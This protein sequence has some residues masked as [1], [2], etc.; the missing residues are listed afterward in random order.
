MTSY[1]LFGGR[2]SLVACSGA[3]LTKDS[4][5]SDS[6][7]PPLSTVHTLRGQSKA[8]MVPLNLPNFL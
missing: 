2:E 5:L 7:M 4:F 3:K 1:R 6:Q 8:Q